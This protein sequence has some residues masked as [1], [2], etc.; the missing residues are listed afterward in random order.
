MSKRLSMDSKEY[1]ALVNNYA[2]NMLVMQGQKIKKKG[3]EKWEMNY[4]IGKVALIG[5]RAKPF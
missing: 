1:K 5:K 2:F 4:F 3:G